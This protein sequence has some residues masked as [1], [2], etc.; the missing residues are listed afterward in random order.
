M[1]AA[2]E[3]VRPLRRWH[4][5]RLA[6]KFGTADDLEPADNKHV[7][8]YD[9][10]LVQARKLARGE[11]NADTETAATASRRSLSARRSTHTRPI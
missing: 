3:L 9:Q 2:S 11:A 8:T 4:R 1:K 10:A 6:E 5:V 7:F